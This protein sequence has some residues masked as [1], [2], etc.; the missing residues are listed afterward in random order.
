MRRWRGVVL[1]GQ[2]VVA[3]RAS[4][5]ARRDRSRPSACCRRSRSSDRRQS[6]ARPRARCGHSLPESATSSSWDCSWLTASA[7]TSRRRIR[8]PEARSAAASASRAS[9]RCRRRQCADRVARIGAAAAPRRAIA[10]AAA[11]SSSFGLGK[12]IAGD[13]RFAFEFGK[14]V[15]LGQPQGRR[16]RRIGTGRRGHPSG[17]PR[18][19]CVTSRWPGF[20]CG[21]S[22]GRIGIRHQADLLQ[23]ARQGCGARDM[24]KRAAWHRPAGPDRPRRRRLR[25]N[26]PAHSDR[27]GIPDRLPSA[28]PSAV[29]KPRSTLQLV[30]DRRRTHPRQRPRACGGI[31]RASVSS[32]LSL[33]RA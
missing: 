12:D 31:V 21:T 26:G 4:A 11:A 14:A 2:A 33:E 18:L 6:R 3:A 13:R 25:T 28:A 17:R 23:A 9:A 7:T 30:R 29:S 8:S 22:V 20:K 32:A 5:S 24:L 16:T 19:R 1:A 27:A 10:S 15:L